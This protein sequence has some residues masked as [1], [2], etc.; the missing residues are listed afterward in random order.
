MLL[1]S[2]LL[3]A[4]MLSLAPTVQAEPSTTK[5]EPKETP[6]CQSCSARHQRL[7]KLKD[8]GLPP[9]KPAPPETAT[10]PGPKGS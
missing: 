8:V 5:A 2:A 9:P 7:K 3:L 6:E 1:R 4:L 10:V